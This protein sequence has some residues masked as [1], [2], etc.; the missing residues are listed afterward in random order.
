MPLKM[1]VLLFATLV[2]GIRF[3]SVLAVVA[4]G[5]MLVLHDRPGA[6]VA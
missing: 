5:M 1:L 3:V 4:L 6:R 2:S